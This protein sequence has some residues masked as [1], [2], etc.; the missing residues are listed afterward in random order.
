MV[1][2]DKS[3]DSDEI[4]GVCRAEHDALP[5]IPNGSLE[6]LRGVSLC[7]LF[8]VVQVSTGRKRT[9]DQSHAPG[10]VGDART[11]AFFGP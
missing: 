6:G 1:L 7:F 3:F 2:R 4:R 11:V 5:M 9:R 8:S 10:P